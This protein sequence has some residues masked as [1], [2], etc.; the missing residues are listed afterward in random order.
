[1]ALTTVPD[2]DASKSLPGSLKQPDKQ[3]MNEGGFWFGLALGVAVMWAAH[4]WGNLWPDP[5]AKAIY[6]ETG[7]PRNCRA[8]VA[9]NIEGLRSGKYTAEGIADSLDR[10]CGSDGYSWGLQ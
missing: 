6:G 3:L 1:M 2:G 4:T 7:L 5:N 9:H 10:N 8:I